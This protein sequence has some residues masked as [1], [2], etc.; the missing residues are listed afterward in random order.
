MAQFLLII[1][2]INQL[3]PLIIQ[4]VQA[5]ESAFP[6]SG[7]GA[8]KLEIVRNVLQSA[9]G[10]LQLAETN[11]EAVWPAINAVITGVVKLKT[12]A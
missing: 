4:T 1:S 3:F 6:Q 10:T 8:A 9:F 7:Q 12:K 11:F 2:I 5:V